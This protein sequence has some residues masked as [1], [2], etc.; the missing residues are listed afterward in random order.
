MPSDSKLLPLVRLLGASALGLIATMGVAAPSLR[1]VLSPAEFERAGLQKLTPEELEFLSARLLPPATATA[2][3]AAPAASSPPPREP[4]AAGRPETRLTG[5]AAFG[6][7]REVQAEVEQ[8]RQ[9]PREIQSR[10]VG[11]FS[12]WGGATLFRLENGQVWQQAEPSVFAVD[13][14]A[15]EVTIRKGHF[16]AFYLTVE[17]YG[18]RVKVKRVK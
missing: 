18:S 6:R 10:I 5:D 13:L 14:N 17:G 2:P 4:A 11:A 16:G 12:G 1:D 3:A 7:E 8:V 15:P 9:I